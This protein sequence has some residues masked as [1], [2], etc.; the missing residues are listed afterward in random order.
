MKFGQIAVYCMIIISNM[1][2]AQ[3]WRLEASSRP[4]NDFI[5]M[6]IWQDL[7]IFNSGHLPF[8]TVPGSPFEKVKLWN[9]E[10]TRY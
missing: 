3:G 9:L 7:A 1:F 4:F 10:V 2:L 6:I 5:K 8:L